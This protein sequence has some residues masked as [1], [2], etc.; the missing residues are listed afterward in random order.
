MHQP[1]DPRP[2]ST[3]RVAVLRLRRPRPRRRGSIR[4]R[5]RMVL[6]VQPRTGSGVRPSLA[7]RV[8]PGRHNHHRLA[9]GQASR[10]DL[11]RVPLPGRVHRRQARRPAPRHTLGPV[12][13]HGGGDRRAATGVGRRRERARP[14]LRHRDPPDPGRR[15]HRWT[16]PHPRNPRARNLGRHRSRCGTRPVASGRPASST[17]TGSWRRTRR[18]GRPRVR[19]TLGSAYPLP[20]SEHPTPAFASSSSPA[21]LFRTPLASD[22]ARGGE[23]LDRVRARRGHDRSVPS[24]HRPGPER[25]GGFTAASGAGTGV[26]ADRAALRR[27]GRYALAIRRWE[28]LT[29]RG[30]PSPTLVSDEGQYRPA[31][32]FV[33]WL[34]GLPDGWVT[35]SGLGLTPP[36]QLTALGNGVVLMR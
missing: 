9:Q 17:S 5:D 16:Q 18:S 23:S 13:A 15:R 11:R 1:N 32:R 27:W 19:R 36:E 24:G 22:A 31:P 28:Y 8:E 25:A 34:M 2:S 6:G 12:G 29:G 30:A 4:R 35:D 3:G 33:E 26:A 20:T 14:A 10:C 7:G 21:A